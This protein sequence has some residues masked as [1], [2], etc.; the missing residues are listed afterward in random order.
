[1]GPLLY[2]IFTNDLPEVVH[3]HEA[4]ITNEVEVSFSLPFL[5]CGGLCAFA[6]DSTFSISRKDPNDLGEALDSK[7][8]DIANYMAANKLL[9]NAEKTHIL[10]LSSARQHRMNE[11][12]G[13]ELNTGSSIIKPSTMERLLGVTVSND[14]TWN[15]H[16][17][18]M[19]NCLQLSYQ[20]FASSAK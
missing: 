8:R 20:I 1:M 11:N 13:I 5:E 3:R 14:F 12:V 2:T 4:Q 6:D 19:D 18:Q 10:I 9:L 16:I 7:Y 15:A 17:L